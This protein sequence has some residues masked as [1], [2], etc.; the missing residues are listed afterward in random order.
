MRTIL[1]LAILFLSAA[2][3]GQTYH[4][5]LKT[6]AWYERYLGLAIDPDTFWYCVD[7]DTIIN[8]IGYTKIRQ[9][10][11]TCLHLLR[12]DTV[13]RRVYGMMYYL[14][15]YGD[16]TER[17]IYDFSLSVGQQMPVYNPY[18]STATLIAVD[19]IGTNA[20]PRRRFH[21]EEDLYQ[22]NIWIVEGVGSLEDLMRVYIS[23]PTSEI[24]F[25]LFCN[26][27]GAQRVY[28]DAFH[29]CAPNPRVLGV[30]I[31]NQGSFAVYPNPTT[32][33]VTMAFPTHK[34][35]VQLTTTGSLG[36]LVLTPL[37]MQADWWQ[38]DL[39]GLPS[40]LYIVTVTDGED[41]HRVK[42]IKQ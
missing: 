1:L 34:H 23:W 27:E 32:G 22:S 8:S 3:R 31:A 2:V 24:A 15:S 36:Q 6:T 10:N 13:Q 21:F 17:L 20:G 12:E 30:D 25:Q 42:V 18:P 16:T 41:T 4:P 7:G 35:D 14:R 26:Y 28:E 33:P 37:M 40:G 9:T 19:T 29:V 11:D 38:M 5:L 39:T